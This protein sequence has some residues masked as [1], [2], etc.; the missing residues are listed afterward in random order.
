M[1]RWKKSMCLSRLVGLCPRCS[2]PERSL[3]RIST[4]V[5]RTVARRK[6]LGLKTASEQSCYVHLQQ[7][8]SCYH[9]ADVTANTLLGCKRSRAPQVAMIVASIFKTTSLFG[10]CHPRSSN[11]ELNPFSL[12]GVTSMSESSLR[13]VAGCDCNSDSRIQ[14][15]QLVARLSSRK[16]F[17]LRRI[18][19][20]TRSAQQCCE[21]ALACPW[22][23]LL[24][25]LST[26]L[27]PLSRALPCR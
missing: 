21:Q 13:L 23:L 3:H 25:L 15:P 12:F 5:E 18:E 26:R 2:H 27:S 16:S 14:D 6:G 17:C 7:S 11:S 20:E 1:D 10:P 22:L 4:E 9:N 19:R 8:S 24:L